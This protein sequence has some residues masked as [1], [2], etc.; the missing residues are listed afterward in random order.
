MTTFTSST[1]NSHNE[2]LVTLLRDVVEKTLWGSEVERMLHNAAV[3]AIAAHLGLEG[4]VK[5]VSAALAD[6]P[7]PAP[8]EPTPVDPGAPA[9]V[10]PVDPTTVAPGD[11]SV[12]ADEPMDGTGT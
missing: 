2:L 1:K 5:D 11:S 10:A 3:D 7:V 8:L 6:N 12:P 4:I 9:P